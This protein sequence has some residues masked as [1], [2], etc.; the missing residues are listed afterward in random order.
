MKKILTVIL[1]LHSTVMAQNIDIDGFARN[2]IGVLIN[3][4]LDYSIIQNTFNLNIYRT[5]DKAGF[6]VNPYI[7]QYDGKN[8]EIGLREAYLDIYFPSI[9]LRI[10]KQQ[11]IWGKAD[12]VFITDIVSP[13]DLTE[14]I[15]RD[16]SEIRMGITAVKG[17]YYIG[18]NTLEL[19]WVPV[20]TPTKLPPKNS[21]WYP[22]RPD[23]PA[24]VN[25]DYSK[26]Q[27]RHDL[28][29]SEF[30]GKVSALT[31]PIDFEI[32]GA[33]TWEDEPTMHLIKHF[34]LSDPQHPLLDS[35]TILPE[36]H[37]LKV[38]GLSFSSSIG[39][40]VLRGEGAFYKGKY[41]NTTEPNITESVIK[42]DYIHYLLGVDC[43][44]KGWNISSQFIQKYIL[45]YDD[46]LQD[47]QFSNMATL[48]IARN[49]MHETL[50]FSLF[51]YYDITTKSSLIR[52]KLSYDVS[53]GFNVLVGLNI[54]T[55]DTGIFGQYGNNDMIYTQ[56]KYNF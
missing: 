29:N 21:I 3:D 52:P 56:V 44:I 55:G 17:D 15:L 36:Y 9:D 49:F 30:F 2:Y 54:F 4:S 19:V 22:K 47:D 33:Y 5:G 28:K 32:M 37:R 13:K 42:K 24:P 40:I 53:D 41:F 26:A 1:L 6:K 43:S 34:N 51:T 35:I 12:G 38:G 45:D 16:F 46:Y 27:V 23:F 7:Y 10:G 48:L 50:H 18:N 20:F 8:L 31:G 25:F 11:I 39:P 14:F